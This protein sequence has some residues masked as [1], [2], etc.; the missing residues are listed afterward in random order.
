MSAINQVFSGVIE[1]LQH[2]VEGVESLFS[3]GAG[4]IKNFIFR[5]VGRDVNNIVAKTISLEQAQILFESKE[6][7]RENDLIAKS[8]RSDLEFDL[9][10]LSER[11]W[12][13]D[14]VEATEH[15]PEKEKGELN[16]SLMADIPTQKVFNAYCRHMLQEAWGDE[17]EWK[18]VTKEARQNI[19][20]GLDR[21]LKAYDP[22]KFTLSDYKEISTE[23]EKIL[24]EITEVSDKHDL[25]GTQM[26]VLKIEKEKIET[27]T[28][29]LTGKFNVME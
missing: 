13:E 7:A 26:G 6:T 11:I 27:L 25:V 22:E 23:I 17:K 15:Y 21:L 14:L 12:Q 24:Y 10:D 28:K 1:K 16:A 3:S 29:Y 19:E 5:L 8:G 2:F 20:V 4:R 18:D 9:T